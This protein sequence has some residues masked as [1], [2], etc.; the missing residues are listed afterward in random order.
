MIFFVSLLAVVIFRYVAG[1]ESVQLAKDKR[2]LSLVFA[3]LAALLL[4]LGGA[5]PAQPFTIDMDL[6]VFGV[7]EAERPAMAQISFTET[8]QADAFLVPIHTRLSSGAAWLW[9]SLILVCLLMLVP[10]MRPKFDHHLYE[11]AH[12]VPPLC[13]TSILLWYTYAGHSGVTESEFMSYLDAFDLPEVAEVTFQVTDWALALDMRMITGST[14]ALF[15]AFFLLMRRE[16]QPVYP[17]AVAVICVL[18]LLGLC[19][20]DLY[21]PQDLA[22]AQ[23]WQVFVVAALG[24]LGIVER[25]SRI[26]LWSASMCVLASLSWGFGA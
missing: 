26:R 17:A 24:I 12:F 15:F 6:V 7:A 4:L 19:L 14:V 22:S 25:E 3:S 13:V 18:L 2:S 1:V 10:V 8:S 23:R 11:K 5:H 9:G 16:V 20:R 21:Q